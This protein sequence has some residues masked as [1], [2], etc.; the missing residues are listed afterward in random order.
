MA[1]PLKDASGDSNIVELLTG[2]VHFG[3]NNCKL[4]TLGETTKKKITSANETNKI[5]SVFQAYS[6]KRK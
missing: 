4:K 6:N 2:W 5:I 3:D 1:S